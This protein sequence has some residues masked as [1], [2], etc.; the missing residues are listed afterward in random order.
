MSTLVEC[1]SD[2]AYAQRPTALHWD[3]RR[4]E[5]E[6]VEAEWRTPEGKGFR[7]RAAGG[8]RFELVYVEASDEWHISHL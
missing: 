2:Y 4:L 3:G 8:H 6:A 1:R 5:V 7:V